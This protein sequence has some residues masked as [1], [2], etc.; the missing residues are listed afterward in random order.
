[1][2]WFLR[3]VKAENYWFSDSA[4]CSL[5]V[6]VVVQWSSCVQLFATP[7]TATCQS[8]LS[9]PISQSLPKFMSIASVMPSS[10][11][12]LWCPLL[13]SIFPSVRNFSDESAVHIK[14]PKYWSFSFSIIFPVN[15]QGWFPLRLTGLISLLSKG[16]SGVF[17][18][19][20]VWRYQF[21]GTPPSLWSRSQNHVTTGKTKPWLYGP[22]WAEQCLCSSTHYLGLS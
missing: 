15:V 19:S 22:L 21:F 10:H 13:P 8:S 14:R 9:R 16:L 17:S 4:G 7:W 20:T 3:V 18:S 12:I 1:M 6:V 11:L 2:G 5:C